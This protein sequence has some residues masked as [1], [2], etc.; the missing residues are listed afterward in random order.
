MKG[1]RSVKRDEDN[2]KGKIG[3]STCERSW[4]SGLMTR[5]GVED[6]IRRVIKVGAWTEMAPRGCRIYSDM[7]ISDWA[8]AIVCE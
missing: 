1:T 5:I 3:N 2:A 8:I 6:E 4:C 7:R